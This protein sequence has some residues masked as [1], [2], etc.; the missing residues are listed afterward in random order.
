MN[1]ATLTLASKVLA[2]QAKAARA[3][4]EVGSYTVDETVLINIAGTVKCGES[5]TQQV[6]AKADPWLLLSVALSHLNGVTVE[7]IVTEALAADPKLVKSLKA[8]AAT[9]VAAVKAPTE[10]TCQGKVTVAKGAAVTVVGSKSQ[11]A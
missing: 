1:A 2:A 4:L 3:D 5:Y 10:T 7:S 9:A 11:A 8:Q 6:V